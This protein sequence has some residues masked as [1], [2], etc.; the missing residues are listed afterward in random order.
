MGIKAVGVINEISVKNIKCYF[1]RKVTQ[2]GNGAK[3]DVPKEF[4]GE[5]AI[6]IV[7]G[8][9]KELNKEIRKVNKISIKN[10]KSYFERAVTKFGTGAKINAPKEY[11]GEKVIVAIKETR[12]ENEK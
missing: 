12:R 6:L 5:E 4:L 1:E 7:I 9:S 3:I 2:F 11:L 8:N 10:F